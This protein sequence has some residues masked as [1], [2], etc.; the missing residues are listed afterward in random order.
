MASANND[1]AQYRRDDDRKAFDRKRSSSALRSCYIG[2]VILGSDRIN[3]S[4]EDALC[5]NQNR[6]IPGL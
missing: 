3:Q 6:C 1:Y 2:W 5:R 4:R